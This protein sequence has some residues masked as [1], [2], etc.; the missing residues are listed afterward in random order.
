[1]TDGLPSKPPS[2]CSEAPEAREGPSA[3]FPRRGGKE[4][5]G[6]GSALRQ[7]A[8]CLSPQAVSSDCSRGHRGDGDVKG[9][10]E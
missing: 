4:V 9:R 5:A 1:M 7:L 3:P 6:A 2:S 8:C 10:K